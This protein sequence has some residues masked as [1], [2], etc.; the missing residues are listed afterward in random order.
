MKNVASNNP[1]PLSAQAIRRLFERIIDESRSVERLFM[2][3]RKKAKK[4]S[5]R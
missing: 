1:G 3:E 5:G 4:G 2:E